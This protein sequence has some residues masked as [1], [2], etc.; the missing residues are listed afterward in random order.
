MLQ[1]VYRITTPLNLDYI[2]SASTLLIKETAGMRS[3]RGGKKLYHR[4]ARKSDLED[5]TLS[6]KVFV[7]QGGTLL[8]HTIMEYSQLRQPY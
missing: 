7:S 5:E 2:F 6:L 3:D 4:N 1:V 8:H